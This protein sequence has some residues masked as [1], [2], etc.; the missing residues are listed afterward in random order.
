MATAVATVG[1]PTG[2]IVERNAFPAAGLT[3]V[4]SLGVAGTAAFATCVVGVVVTGVAAGLVASGF[5]VA[6]GST[7]AAVSVGGSAGI[8]AA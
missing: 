6:A 3:A 2:V 1:S 4:S 8:M 7:A 5:A